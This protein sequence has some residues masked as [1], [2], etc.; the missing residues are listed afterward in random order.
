MG[1]G[2]GRWSA[3]CRG[4]GLPAEAANPFEGSGDIMPQGATAE[5]LGILK[6]QAKELRIQLDRIRQRIED[7]EKS[8]E[9]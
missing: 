7:I 4:W 5:D 9:E 2:A 1:G 8:E 6:A 3:W